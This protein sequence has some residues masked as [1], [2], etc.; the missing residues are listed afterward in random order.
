M[1]YT[2]L[3]V[4]AILEAISKTH[5]GN[6]ESIQTRDG[7]ED[8]GGEIVLQGPNWGNV[9]ILVIIAMLVLWFGVLRKDP[10]TSNS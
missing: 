9:F 3:L 5:I 10:K 4:F 6:T 7:I 2:A 8:V 1:I